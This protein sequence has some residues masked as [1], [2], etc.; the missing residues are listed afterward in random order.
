MFV[1]VLVIDMCSIEITWNKCSCHKT[2]D[3]SLNVHLLLV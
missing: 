2:M 1:F 3:C